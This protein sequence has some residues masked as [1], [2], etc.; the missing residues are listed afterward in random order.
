MRLPITPLKCAV[1]LA[2]IVLTTTDLTSV[3]L[4]QQT[5]SNPSSQPVSGSNTLSQAQI[6]SIVS[7]FTVKETEFR[8]ALNSY[9]FKRD[10]LVQVIG[11]GGQVTGEYHRV[12]EFTF[13]DAGNRFEKITFF[14]MSSIGEI[15]TAED[16][17]D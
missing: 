12:S 13:D 17:E 6:D 1:A 4:A 15:I 11:M 7:K 2:A 5:T 16:L 14:P 10:A 3:A 8:R 9:A